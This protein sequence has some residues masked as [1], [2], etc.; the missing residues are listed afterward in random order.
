MRKDRLKHIT[1]IGSVH[2]ASDKLC[3]CAVVKVMSQIYLLS[4]FL[5]FSTNFR[6]PTYFMTIASNHEQAK[7]L[8]PL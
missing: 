2:P 4:T 3:G 8:S 1:Y 7:Y 5:L 6:S